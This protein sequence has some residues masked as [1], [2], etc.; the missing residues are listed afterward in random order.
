[1][2]R[3]EKCLSKLRDLNELVSITHHKD[4]LT[5]DFISNFKVDYIF[6][7]LY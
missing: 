3:A 7:N 2:N 5:P 1:M 6:C 4:E